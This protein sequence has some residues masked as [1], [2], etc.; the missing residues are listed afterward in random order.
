MLKIDNKLHVQANVIIMQIWE[1]AI[2]HL[3]IVSYLR[4]A[5]MSVLKNLVIISIDWM[6]SRYIQQSETDLM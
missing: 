6:V 2:I 3:C 1:I 4:K 5:F